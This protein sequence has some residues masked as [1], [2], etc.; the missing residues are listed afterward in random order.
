MLAAA[1]CSKHRNSQS[2]SLSNCMRTHLNSC[3]SYCRWKAKATGCSSCGLT[4]LPRFAL[5]RA[6]PLTACITIFWRKCLKFIQC[7]LSCPDDFSQSSVFLDK[8]GR[9]R[10]I[11][12]LWVLSTIKG[13]VNTQALLV[14]SNRYFA[15]NSVVADSRQPADCLMIVSRGLVEVCL[16]VKEGGRVLRVLKRG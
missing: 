14:A 16:P 6:C 12:R 13:F 3:H 8:C 4:L 1:R 9:D 10:L 11:L 15:A 7:S 2:I 5:D